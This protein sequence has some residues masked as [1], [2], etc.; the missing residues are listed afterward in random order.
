MRVHGLGSS[1][2]FGAAV[3]IALVFM[4]HV[5]APMLGSW[6]VLAFYLVGCTVAYAALIGRTR[7]ASLRNAMV[8]AIGAVAVF[9]LARGSHAGMGEVAI[10]LTCV[11]A[12]VRSGLDPALRRTR[13]FVIESGLGGASLVF[14]A[15]LATPGWLGSAVALWGYV[16][17]QS[18]YFLIPRSRDA[19]RGECV[20]D[21]FDRARERLIAMLEEV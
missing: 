20:G 18:L 7:R 19:H 1:L 3:S 2:V 9:A 10:G 13:S 6:N 5:F 17:V 14:A 4:Q 21:P 8:G 12:L 16:L 15:W 11:V